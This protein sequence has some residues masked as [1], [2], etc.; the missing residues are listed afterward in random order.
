M[1]ISGSKWARIL[2]ALLVVTVVLS[3]L[4]AACAP[5]DDG[6]SGG[7]GGGGKDGDGDKDKDKGKDDGGDKDKDKGSG[8]GGSDSGSSEGGN[9]TGGSTEGGS[10]DDGKNKDGGSGDVG[11]AG[12]GGS[13]CDQADNCEKIDSPGNTGSMT[14]GPGV[15]NITFKAGQNEF[16]V[17]V[18]TKPG[19]TNCTGGYC[20]TLNAD[21]TVSWTTGSGSKDISHI[22]I[23]ECNPA[24]DPNCAPPPP[25]DPAKDPA[26]APVCDPAKD[27]A[28]APVCDPAKDPSCAPVCDPAKDPSC[29]PVCDPLVDPACKPPVC[30]PKTD[31]ACAPKCDPAK[32]PT[33]A[34]VCDP[35]KDP[36]CAPPRCK[37]NECVVKAA[38]APGPTCPQWIV[39]HSFRSGDLEIFRLDGVEAADGSNVINLSRHNAMDSRPSRSPDDKFVVF[40]SN[41]QGNLE[42]YMTD[43]EGAQQTRLT[44]TKSNNV[45]AMVGPDNEHVIFQSDRNGNWDLYLLNVKTGADKQLTSST[46]DDVNA[47]WSPDPNWI[48]FQSNRTGAWNV[49]LLNL[50]TGTEYSVTSQSKDIVFPSWSPNGR[51]LAFFADWGGK[52]TLYISDLQGGSIKRLAHQ[53]NAGNATWSPEGNRIAYQ[54]EG[55]NSNTDVFTFD[56]TTE[57]QYQL[58]TFNGPDSAP[59]WDCGGAN[60]SFTSTS[61]GSPNIY[62]VPWRGGDIDYITITPFTNKW[63]E[64]SPSKEPGSR[65]Y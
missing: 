60:V 24:T 41:R 16:D 33:C 64:W 53:G 61:E 8:G 35:A 45:N 14:L 54:V 65:G 3:M 2:F 25:C 42:L 31:P 48:V 28:C 13:E 20:V 1:K 38:P 15:T 55:S 44:T 21:G 9:A 52:L 59:T 6:L 7:A 19:E 56:L 37:G 5:A 36:S 23:W 22:Q 26:C 58:T 32:D 27:P 29:A 10:Q 47:Y 43:S 4:L 50:S 46:G 18:P 63:S 49:Y 39:F 11:P 34:P 51:Q 30:D 62:K 57:E 40:Q 17:P 12:P